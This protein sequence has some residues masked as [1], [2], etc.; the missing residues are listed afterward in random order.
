MSQGRGATLST[1]SVDAIFDKFKPLLNTL[2]KKVRTIEA[3]IKALDTQLEG[4]QSS[5]TAMQTEVAE[6]RKEQAAIASKFDDMQLCRRAHPTRS[7]TSSSR[8]AKT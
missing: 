7:S 2:I 8:A 6:L 4:V 1:A 5:I 3:G